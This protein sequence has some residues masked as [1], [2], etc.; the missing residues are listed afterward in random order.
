LKIGA[1]RR[2]LSGREVVFV[3]ILGER[4]GVRLCSEREGGVGL[5]YERVG[6]FQVALPVRGVSASF[7]TERGDVGMPF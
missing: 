2:H 4:G 1:P 6:G 7:M 5:L 3:G